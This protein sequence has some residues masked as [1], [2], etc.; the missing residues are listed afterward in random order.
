M[1][2]RFFDKKRKEFLELKESR[3]SVAEYEREFVRLN[4]YAQECVPIEVAM[5]TRFVDYLNEDIKLL[6][7]I[8]ELKEFVILVDRVHKAKELSKAKRKVDSEAYDSRKRPMGKSFSSSWKKSKEFHSHSSALV[9]YS[10]RDKGKK[11]ELK[12]SGYICSEL[13]DGS[14][15]KCGSDDHYLRDFSERSAKEKAKTTRP[16]NTT[17]R[18]R[19]SRNT[20][21]ADNSHSG[22]K[23]S[24]MRS[25]AWAPA[26]AYA[27]RARKET[28]APDVIIGTIFFLDTN[29]NV[30]IDPGSMRSYVGIT[31]VSDKKIPFESTKFVIK[32]MNP[33]GYYVLVDK[34][35][36]NCPLMIQGCNFPTDLMLLPFDEF[37]VIQGID[38]LALYDAIV[39]YRQKHIVLKC[40]NGSKL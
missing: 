16:S 17:V 13:K 38:W 3:M 14:C 1:S 30:L 10:G 35:C 19:P 5:C 39:N 28:L 7:G 11:I 6:V 20:G 26:R 21:N 25:K 36:K 23:D 12:T 34:V 37:D 2:Q 9:G 15:F 29:V 32:V 27:I 33:L 24:T 4:K 8:L 31:L 18:G 22:T 40:Q